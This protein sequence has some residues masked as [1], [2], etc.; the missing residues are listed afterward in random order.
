MDLYV[1]ASG[2][3]RKIFLYVFYHAIKKIWGLVKEQFINRL[4]NAEKVNAFIRKEE[5]EV[6]TSLG[7][8]ELAAHYQSYHAAYMDSL[9]KEEA[10]RLA[11]LKA[12]QLAQGKCG[13]KT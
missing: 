7:E 4:S 1:I 13:N 3:A 11:R 12:E 9:Q 5:I 6:L 2:R 8:R 10:E